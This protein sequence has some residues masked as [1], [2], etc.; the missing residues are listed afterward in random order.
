MPSAT[1]GGRTHAYAPPAALC[2]SVE[3][4]TPEHPQDVPPSAPAVAATPLR[5]AGCTAD[6][7]GVNALDPCP[8][9]GTRV[10]ASLALPAGGAPP[11]PPRTLSEFTP[12]LSCGYD[13]KG[14]DAFGTCPECGHA[15][16][17]SLAGPLLR[18][19]SPEY[20]RTLSNGAL[21]CTLWMALLAPTWIPGVPAVLTTRA[22][23]QVIASSISLLAAGLFA[24][25]A[26]L[27]SARD[28]G[29][30]DSFPGE[31]D[32]RWLRGYA[33]AFALLTIVDHA[34]TIVTRGPREAYGLF[35]KNSAIAIVS[36]V[37]V[38]LAI[39]TYFFLM[40]HVR[41]LARRAVDRS[42]RDMNLQLT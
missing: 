41:W 31:R 19:S 38:M 14:L 18:N 27:L 24:A 3:G 34:G 2:S 36:I 1:R 39:P 23:G 32:R 30:G 5:C 12:C 8:F 22:A 37:R 11:L 35:A 25:G 40:F 20:L 15:V 17:A 26:W 33:V 10:A 21:L 7:S 6:I 13:L 16:Q 42:L 28:A 29:L 9:C 4:S